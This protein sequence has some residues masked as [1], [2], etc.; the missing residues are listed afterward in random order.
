[1]K[2]LQSHPKKSPLTTQIEV[3]REIEPAGQQTPPSPID[4][5]NNPLHALTELVERLEALEHLPLI[6]KNSSEACGHTPAQDGNHANSAAQVDQILRL[7]QKQ[8]AILRRLA[9]KLN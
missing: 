7:F 2:V 9:S 6:E 5:E 3:I 4:E 1:M 8:N